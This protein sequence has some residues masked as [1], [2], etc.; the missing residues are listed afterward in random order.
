MAITGG[1]L[2][3]KA[4]FAIDAD[5]PLRVRQC[6][7][8]L[9]QYLSAGGGAINATF[10]KQAITVTGETAVFTSIADSGATLHRTF[11]PSCGAPLFSE[12]EPR[13][14]LITVRAG[15]LDDPELAKPGAIIWTKMAPTWA[16][17]DPALPRCEGQP[18]T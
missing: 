1:C 7:C 12:A 5:K 10:P 2:C 11:C 6:W 16:C 4:R 3:G 13:P 8:R 14:H 18:P 17:F 9:C 15:A